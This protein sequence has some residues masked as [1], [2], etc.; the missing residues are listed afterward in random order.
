MKTQEEQDSYLQ[1]DL[2]LFELFKMIL[3]RKKLIAGVVTA[4]V[5]LSIIYSLLLPKIYFGEAILNLPIVTQQ[6]LLSQ[7]VLLYSP[8]VDVEDIEMVIGSMNEEKLNNTFNLI[9]DLK[10]TYDRQHNIKLSI[11]VENPEDVPKVVSEFTHYVEHISYIKNIVDKK[12]ALL[13]N[14]L[15]LLTPSIESRRSLLKTLDLSPEKGETSTLS[16]VLSE[17]IQTDIDEL[18][19]EKSIIEEIIENTK[20]V[21]VISTNISEEPLKSNIRRNIFLAIIVGFFAALIIVA[22]WELYKKF[23]KINL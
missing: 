9:E 11:Y 3:K 23:S 12:R 16:F 21:E 10:I 18:S 15:Q 5:S 17:I 2:D 19:F 20:A 22:F 14:K 4:S 1:D 6:I 7:G 13:S 8:H